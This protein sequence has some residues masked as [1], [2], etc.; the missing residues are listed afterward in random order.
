VQRTTSS[1]TGIPAA[2]RVLY[3]PFRA[4][5][6]VRRGWHGRGRR[7]MGAAEAADTGGGEVTDIGEERRAE[8]DEANGWWCLPR[9][10]YRHA[11]VEVKRESQARRMRPT[12]TIQSSSVAGWNATTHQTITLLPT[13]LAAAIPSLQ[14][15]TSTAKSLSPLT[16]LRRPSPCRRR[17]RRACWCVILAAG[18]ELLLHACKVCLDAQAAASQLA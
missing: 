4:D 8:E 14:R 12:G 9:R 15:G 16:L 17:H 18:P 2:R 6:S 3:S 5:H 1:S 10:R 13:I 11:P 7:T